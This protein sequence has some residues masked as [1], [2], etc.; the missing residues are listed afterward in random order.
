MRPVSSVPTERF[1][2]S[3]ISK[4]RYWRSGFGTLQ[5]HRTNALFQRG[6]LR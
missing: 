5:E 4:S 3:L 1:S 6:V 2:V